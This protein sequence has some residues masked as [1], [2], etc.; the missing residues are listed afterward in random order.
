LTLLNPGDT[1]PAIIVPRAGGGTITLPDDLAGG[2]AVVLFYRGSWC[3]Y[4]NAQLRAFQR[5]T[6]T[7]AELGAR[8]VALSVDDE[9]T[10]SELIA[11][12]SP[13][14]SVTVPTPKRSPKRRAPSSTLTA[15]SSSPPGSS[16]IPTA[17]WLSASTPPGRS[18][19]S[20][21][22]TLS[23]C[24]ATYDRVPRPDLPPDDERGRTA[25]SHVRVQALP[26]GGEP[27][28]CGPTRLAGRAF[29][30]PHLIWRR[31]SPYSAPQSTAA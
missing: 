10:S 3:P 25:T 19:A 4:C 29:V 15:A 9:A 20:C 16:S 13:S 31:Q 21:P 28:G 2:F 17:R 11:K 23:A 14:R 30:G 18:A 27:T 7:L 8:V 5:A 24:S 26:H 12:A 6:D 1:F 22:T